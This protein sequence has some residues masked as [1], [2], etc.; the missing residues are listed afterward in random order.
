MQD[1]PEFAELVTRLER[2]MATSD[3]LILLDDRTLALARLLLPLAHDDVR[4]AHTVGW[5]HWYRA[6][7]APRGQE[8]ADLFLAIDLFT[9]VYEVDPSQVPAEVR[10]EF[11]AEEVPDQYSRE[12]V[13]QYGRDRLAE[14]RRTGD[15]VALHEAIAA[16]QHSA[17]DA[18]ANHPEL[19]SWL[20]N[21]SIAL[22]LRHQATGD[23]EDLDES[24]STAREA[25]ALTEDGHVDHAFR[26]NALATA[27][28]LRFYRDDSLDDLN[29][30]ITLTRRVVELTPAANPNRGAFM[31]NLGVALLTRHERTHALT[32]LDEALSVGQG[33]ADAAPDEQRPRAL[34]N[35]AL[36]WL[37][38]F[39]ASGDTASLDRALALG[40]QA[41]RTV[42]DGDPQR[43]DTLHNLALVRRVR[44]EHLG[45]V[46]DLHAGIAVIREVEREL[47]DGHP[48]KVIA[49]D[50]L[51]SALLI[52]H[53]REGAA[54][55]L[56]EAVAAANAA[57]EQSAGDR[58]GRP[59]RRNTVAKALLQRHRLRGDRA[60]LE[61]AIGVA[62]QAVAE[63]AS[64]DPDRA[65]VLDTL[66]GALQQRFE[67]GGTRSDLDEAVMAWRAAVASTAGERANR[68]DLVGNLAAAMTLRYLALGGPSDLVEAVDLA[69]QAVEATPA[70]HPNRPIRLANLAV[71]LQQRY[72]ELGD[73]AELNAAVA[74]LEETVRATPDGHGNQGMFLSNLAL[75]LSARDELTG[76]DL[77]GAVAAL[78]AAVRATPADHLHRAAFLRNL[79]NTLHQRHRR[80]GTPEDL[81]RAM[82]CFRA[83]AAVPAA[84]VSD[85]AEAAARY[86]D[87]AVGSR[88]WAEAAD[89]YR[90]VV[91]ALPLLAGQHQARADQQ[92]VLAAMTGVGCD[93][94]AV[95]VQQG[96]PVGALRLLEQG[97]GVLIGRSLDLRGELGALRDID[98]A[99]ATRF[100]E[101]R[102]ALDTPAGAQ[103]GTGLTSDARHHLAAELDTLIAEIRS[104]PGMADFL[105]PP[106]LS[107]LATVGPVIAVNASRHRCDA[108]I[109]TRAGNVE[110]CPLPDLRRADAT[111]RANQLIDAT[112]PGGTG[113]AADLRAVLAWLWEVIAEPVLSHLDIQAGSGTPPRLWWLPT[114]PL[115]VLPLHAAGTY[116]AAG[117]H[118]GVPD[119]AVSSTVSTL[120]ALAAAHARPADP[121]PATVLAIAVPEADG[122]P[123]LPNAEAEAAMVTAAIPSQA[124]TLIGPQATRDAVLA[125]LPRASV[126]HFACHAT[127]EFTDPSTSGLALS[128]GPLSVLDLST[129]QVADARLA[130][131]SAC[132]TASG[133]ALVDEAIHLSSAFQ[134]A[135][136]RH[137][138]G[139]LWPIADDLAEQLARAIYTDLAAHPDAV[140][141]AVHRATIHMRQKYPRN[142]HT[143]AAHLHLGP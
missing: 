68:A 27:H 18:P 128:D 22:Q 62:R 54:A 35:L 28:Q 105:A 63:I 133:G 7:A 52:R 129:I 134:L 118:R 119:L 30:V 56:D 13:G 24:I 135:G 100:E 111:A 84:P 65:L 53:D 39:E 81:A 112:R 3:P 47:P 136:Y 93:A 83:A 108:L 110:V 138:V 48:H 92:R 1:N 17:N 20:S 130:Y 8:T 131:L 70:G 132:E 2:F 50:G 11:A 78:D 126:A 38:R 31:A 34:S 32:D 143:W 10:R 5:T 99:L 89:G 26:V 76:S 79:G 12:E 115:T 94:A 60:D 58:T 107:A 120:R 123:P 41:V 55:D 29:T 19:A 139:T 114:G 96:D 101:L 90:I 109:L 75:A 37:R 85:R 51:A 102:D 104:Q 88:R 67:I 21:L 86:A 141:A 4:V 116:D 46:A 14:A 45:D 127:S 33:A 66:A 40:R 87:L 124:R 137:V 73:A 72:D 121:G 43:L 125:A 59:G 69:R 122:L 44:Y 25:V 49:L 36:I 15:P 61:R 91:E 9:R 77:D 103:P 57:I 95:A 23:P 71:V 74:A 16:F 6:M 142:P 42:R 140:A 106:A 117:R 80:K 98:P 113:S 82:D 64:D 97:R